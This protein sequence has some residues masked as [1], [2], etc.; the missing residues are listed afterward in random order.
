MTVPKRLKRN[1]L[2]VVAY[3]GTARLEWSLLPDCVEARDH[4]MLGHYL[5]KLGHEIKSLA[6]VVYPPR[7]GEIHALPPD[8][9]KD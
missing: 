2:N 7:L 3:I 5:I 1:R 8:E 6:G 9:R 4:V